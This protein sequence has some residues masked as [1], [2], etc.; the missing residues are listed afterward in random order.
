LPNG[1]LLVAT[2]SDGVFRR[3]KDGTWSNATAGLPSRSAGDLALGPDGT[4]YISTTSGI[5][6]SATWSEEAK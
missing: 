4:V 6:G 2:F 3:A 5:Y 1:E